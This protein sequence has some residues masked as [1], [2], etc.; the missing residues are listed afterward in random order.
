[1]KKLFQGHQGT[2]IL[3][4]ILI[5]MAFKINS[6]LSIQED[7]A[8]L[9]KIFQDL[10]YALGH[11]FKVEVKLAIFLAHFQFDK[12]PGVAHYIGNLKFIKVSYEVAR[13]GIEDITSPVTIG[14][15]PNAHSMKALSTAPTQYSLLEHVLRVH[16]ANTCTRLTSL[17]RPN[18]MAQ[19]HLGGTSD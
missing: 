17:L 8:R 7:V 3:R 11:E 12:R 15:N 6:S 14:A 16:N 13:I 10:D 4:L 2:D 1:M 19:V 5:L 9:H 18:R